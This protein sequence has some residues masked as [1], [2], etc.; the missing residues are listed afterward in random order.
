MLGQQSTDF[1]VLCL[2]DSVNAIIAA[3]SGTNVDL[4][5]LRPHFNLQV[6]RDIFGSGSDL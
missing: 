3:D 5:H 1:S 6:M 2:D 4:A